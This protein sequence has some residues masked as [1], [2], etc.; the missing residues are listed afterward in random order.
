MCV[1]AFVRY[2]E[3]GTSITCRRACFFPSLVCRDE[4]H[5]VLHGGGEGLELDTTFEKLQGAA[6]RHIGAL[7]ALW[8]I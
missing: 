4:H 7:A 5:A 3:L 1:A 6:R 8:E 2:L